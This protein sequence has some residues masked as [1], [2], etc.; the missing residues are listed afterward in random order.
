MDGS[1]PFGA[2]GRMKTEKGCHPKHPK[3]HHCPNPHRKRRAATFFFSQVSHPDQKGDS[4]TGV[5][6]LLGFLIAHKGP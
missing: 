6:F 1:R 4:L 5:I 3:T 2:T